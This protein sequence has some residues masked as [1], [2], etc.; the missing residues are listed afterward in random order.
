[1][2][3]IGLVLAGYR[4]RS[5]P[6]PPGKSRE[7]RI[8]SAIAIPHPPLSSV[9]SLRAKVTTGQDRFTVER[10]GQEIEPRLDVL[11]RLFLDPSS[12]A[13]RAAASDVL[14][15]QVHLSGFLPP[16]EAPILGQAGMSVHRQELPRENG[17]DAATTE[18]DPEGFLKAVMNLISPQS[19]L[20]SASFKVIEIQGALAS[21]ALES[22]VVFE[23]AGAV[24]SAPG[25]GERRQRSGTAVLSWRKEGREKEGP[26][27]GAWKLAR[28]Q[29]KES[30]RATL[31]ATP[32]QDVTGAALG[33]NLSYRDLILPSIDHFR[34]RIDAASGMDVYGHH[35][36]AVGDANGDGLDDI[37][38]AMPP[39]LPNLLYLGL[40]D[41]TFADGSR[42]SGADALDGTYQALFLDLEND[43]D[44]DLFLVTETGI[45]LLA[46]DGRGRFAETPSGLPDMS[47]SR[48]TPISAAVA[49]YDI[50]GFA[51]AYVC[52]YVFWRGT[53]GEVGS[54]LPFPYHEAHNGAPNFLFRNRGD[55]T[56]E[57][58]TE[59]SGLDVDNNRFSFAAS[60][61]DYDSD[62]DPDIYVANDFGSN[63]L[64][65]N[66]GNGTFTE[67]TR[68]AGVEDVGAGMSVAWEDYDLDGDLDLYVGN[69]LS[70][71]GRRVTGTPDYKQASPEL[72][73][74]YR[75]HARGNSLFRNRG[76]GTF[77]DVSEATRAHFGR[78]AWSSGFVDFNLDGREDI[79]VQNGFISN[80]RKDDL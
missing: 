19:K 79:F 10:A 18:A 68:E 35:G 44:Q 63:N 30:V 4:L 29:T 71:A 31:R 2:F 43:G 75:R 47:V 61:G 72:Q 22:T 64:Y 36:A 67:V 28:W 49:D 23:L 51:D 65:R 58:A 11:K 76:D 74:L 42:E 27:N 80:A 37:Y 21:G 50:D 15:R 7:G 17:E 48:A 55:G 39:G 26:E 8:V 32:F 14:S 53:V 9:E 40:N 13:A 57:D 69:M 24:G 12:D 45:L 62:G 38:V 1:M 25:K 20:D 34:E 73:K 70:S 77:E 66:G 16:G 78:W 56:F 3:G 33:A 59:K 6:D 46:N 41:G 60:W 52:S 5:P 54:R